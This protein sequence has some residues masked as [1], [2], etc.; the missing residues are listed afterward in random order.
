MEVVDREALPLHLT[1]RIIR[2]WPWLVW[3]IVKANVVVTR[4]VLSPSL[5]ISPTV[6]KVPARQRTELCQVIFANSITLT[7]GT[8][9]IDIV[10]GM[11]TV[12]ALTAAAAAD[13]ETG[14][15][16]RRVAV[17]EGTA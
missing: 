9:S 2:Y 12:H 1:W 7:P 11:I 4:Q 14:E 3:E 10:Q 6:I 8:I 15:M 16:N 13:V 17:I 5:P